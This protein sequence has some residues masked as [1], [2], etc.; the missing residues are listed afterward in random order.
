MKTLS[1]FSLALVIVA[2]AQP[3]LAY[4]G[5]G[6]GL[7]VLGALWGLILALLAALGFVLMWPL[8]RYRHRRAQAAAT[9]P[10]EHAAERATGDGADAPDEHR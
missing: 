6:A 2:F 7:S 1:R 4:V 5:P 9:A 3:S 8:R 10:H